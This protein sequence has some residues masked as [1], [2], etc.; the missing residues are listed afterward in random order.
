MYKVSKISKIRL[1]NQVYEIVKEMIINHRFK[2][3]TRV[4]IEQIVKEV[5]V[6]RTPVWEAVHRLMQEGLL[7]NIPNRGVFIVTLTPQTALELYMVREVLEGLAARLAV[8]NMDDRAIKKM[9][10]CLDDQ[11]GV[12]QKKDLIG[13]SKLDFNFHA[14]VYELCGNR[15]LQEMLEAIKNKMRPLALHIDPILSKLYRDHIEIMESLKAMDQGRAEKA[16]HRHNRLM[17][18]HIKRYMEGDLWKEVSDVK[19]ILHK[20]KRLQAPKKAT[21]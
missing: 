1:S 14:I 6:S 3:G 5:G 16:F 11:L 12:V 19:T 21:L 18:G 2:P 17:I 10:K 15:V 20:D 13:Y 4:N 9:A 7:K 8:Q